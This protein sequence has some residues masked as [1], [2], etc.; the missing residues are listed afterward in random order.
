[1]TSNA[2]LAKWTVSELLGLYASL[3]DELRKR[4]VTHSTNNPVADYTE[5]LVTNALK[6][7]PAPGSTSGH[8][9]TDAKATIRD[10]HVG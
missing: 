2:F 3:L 10:G 1:M 6:L 9:A 8:D 7:T 5:Y 4:E